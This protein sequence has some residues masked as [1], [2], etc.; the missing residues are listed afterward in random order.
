MSVLI[1]DVIPYL[2]DQVCLVSYFVEC[3]LS[4]IWI[5]LAIMKV[6]LMGLIGLCTLPSSP[7]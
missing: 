7:Y 2:L 3:I 1:S 5:N 6:A 4:V